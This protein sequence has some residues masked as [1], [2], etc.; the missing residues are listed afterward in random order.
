MQFTNQQ[1]EIDTLPDVRQITF[2]PLEIKHR[3]ISI[4]STAI[5]MVGLLLIF[6]IV[7]MFEETLFEAPVLLIVISTWIILFLLFIFL[8]YKKYYFEGYV[9][10]ERD[11]VYKSGLIFRSQ[12]V[13]PFNRV[14]H[15]EV[16]QGPLDRWVKL[17]SLS[18]FTAG[19][20]SSDLTIPGLKP[21]RASKMKDYIVG[22]IAQDEEE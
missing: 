22:K 18:I 12:I 16:Q 7:G 1:I 20:S 9:L 6:I 5:M 10:R 15:C 13:I 2:I 4:L 17:A 21:D 8:S 3:D 14:Q 11:I 19:G